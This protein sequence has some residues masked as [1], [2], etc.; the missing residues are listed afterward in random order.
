[1]DRVCEERAAKGRAGGVNRK[2][3]KRRL[4]TG[5]GLFALG[6]GFMIFGSARGEAEE[7]FRK[8]VIVCLE[9]IGIG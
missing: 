2:A 8:A 7:I 1:M 3:A 9:C 6:A 4:L 5:I